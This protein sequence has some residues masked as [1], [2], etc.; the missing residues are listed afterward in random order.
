MADISLGSVIVH[1]LIK[2]QH[3][4]FNHAKPFDRR[5][6]V[7]DRNNEIVIKLVTNIAALYGKKSNSPH[8]GIFK[9]DVTKRGPI[10]GLFDI[11]SDETSGK[12]DDEKFISLS[13][14]VMTELY[15]EAK[16]RQASSGGYLLFADYLNNGNRFFIVAMIKQKDGITISQNLEP[17][18]L[19]HLDL[20]KLNQAARISFKRYSEYKT[21]SEEE[22]Q[23][24]NYLSFVSPSNNQAASGYFIAAL[25]CDKGTA[26]SKAT[27]N[28]I[29]ESYNF[30]QSHAELKTN[31][32]KFKQDIINYFSECVEKDIS[33]KLST[34]ENMARNYMT[35]FEEDVRD[36]L[37]TQLYEHLNSEEIR[38]PVEFVISSS[39]LNKIKNIKYR[40]NNL[41][42]D[43]NKNLLGSSS[44]A[45]IC[46]NKENGH[47][48]FT[49]IPAEKRSEIFQAL[50]ELEYA[51]KK[52]E[53]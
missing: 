24:L 17:E 52:G 46:Y 4:E 6:N 27:K 39:S 43:F 12:L 31:A 3:K 2:E 13:N 19:E 11:Y 9:T 5:K 14:E 51:R 36:T 26:S 28:A 48:T 33:A 16:D 40:S 20:S 1:K 32:K 8:Y 41:S 18:E 25:G 44:D 10:P 42:F 23:E 37:A 34:I 47:L 49:R 30:F 50:E 38:I 53:A 45:E 29:L 21:S 22:K 35:H 7:L 15:R